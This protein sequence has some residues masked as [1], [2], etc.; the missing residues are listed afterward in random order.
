MR[1]FDCIGFATWNVA[2]HNDLCFALLRRFEEF[3]YD[4]TNSDDL[5]FE[6]W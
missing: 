5:A 6:G 4:P 3:A 2:Q 1:Q